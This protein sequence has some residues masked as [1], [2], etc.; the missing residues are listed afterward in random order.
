MKKLGMVLSLLLVIGFCGCQ[1]TKTEYSETM[2]ESAVVEDVIY[3][4]SQHST[5]VSPTVRVDMDG[6]LHT[7]LAVTSV[8]VPEKYSVVFHCEHDTKF[9]IQGTDQRH[10]ALWQKVQRGQ[11]VTVSYREVYKTVYD[12]EELISRDLIDYDFLDVKPR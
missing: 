6:D 7:G 5:T 2:Y 4:P 8:S 3:T 12:G 10:K 9:I 11:T 1:R